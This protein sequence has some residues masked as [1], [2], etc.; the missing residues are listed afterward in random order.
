[1]LADIA[2][3]IAAVVIASGLIQNGAQFVLFFVAWGA[4]IKRPEETP[5]TRLWRQFSPVA[6]GI[7]LLAPAYNEEATIVESVRSLLALHYPNFEVIVINDG[8][9]DR[10]LEQLVR[11]FE[12]EATVRRI[13]DTVN[14]APIRAV[15]TAPHQPRLIVLDKVNGGKADALNAGLNAA[16]SDLVC[17]MDADSLLEPDALLHAVGPFVEDSERVIAVGGSVRAVNG[18]RIEHGRVTDYRLPRHPLALMQ[19]VEYLRAFL[20]ARL[21]F[22]RLNMLML[23]SGAFG[24]FRRDA[25]IAVGGYSHGTVGEDMELVIKLHRRFGPEGKRI[26]FAPDAVCWTEVPEDLATLGRQRARWHRGCLEVFARHGTIT[27]KPHHGALGMIG[28]PYILVSDVIGPLVE[29]L[30]YGLLICFW[31]LGWLSLDWVLALYLLTFAMGT[32][33]SMGAI[34][35]EE[36]RLR[37]F[38]TAAGMVRAAVAA[39]VENFGYR[40]LNLFWR[41]H[42]TIQALRHEQGWGQQRRRGF[43]AGPTPV[44]Q[45]V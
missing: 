31:L 41:L 14:H 35:L 34:A 38:P 9:S 19:A 20:M 44:R 2:H 45:T 5:E 16:R 1:M 30:G 3:I 12:L 26:T 11:S 17:S 24:L 23:I 10:T 29:L 7:S 36:R 43:K 32:L 15:Y 6:P 40:Q 21:A 42:G 28:M 37:R 33:L 8:S 39:V 4:L 27:F 13:G 25:V 22:A 18:C